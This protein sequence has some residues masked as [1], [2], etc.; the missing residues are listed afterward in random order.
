MGELLNKN[1]VDA[2]RE[3]LSLG[4]PTSPMTSSSRSAPR[5][6]WARRKLRYLPRCCTTSGTSCT[7]PTTT[8]CGDIV[9]L[10]AEWLT[11]A[12]G[13]VLED[14]PTRDGGGVLEHRRLREIWTDEL[15]YPTKY[16]P[17]FLR[18]ME[19]FDVSYRLPDREASLVGQL[20]DRTVHGDRQLA[21]G[22]PGRETGWLDAGPHAAQGVG[23]PQGHGIPDRHVRPA[24]PGAGRGV[25]EPVRRAL[26][27]AGPWRANHGAATDPGLRR[28]CLGA[29]V[30]LRLAAGVQ[31][32]VPAAVPDLPGPGGAAGDRRRGRQGLPAAHHTTPDPA[33]V[34]KFLS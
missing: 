24:L 9:V 23:A 28:A 10:Q 1:W 29:G 5:T 12:I 16:H 4:R 15:G 34:G 8:V 17:Y 21:S 26:L 14:L 3:I 27:P 25:P 2:R 7:M 11:K 33:L 22:V 31:G 20:A 6:A 32:E 30:R 13:F 19:K 18:L